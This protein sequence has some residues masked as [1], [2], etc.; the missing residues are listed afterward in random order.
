[1]NADQL[2]R[3]ARRVAAVVAEMNE[4]QRRLAVLRTAPDRY[5]IEPNEPPATYDEFLARTSGLLLHEPPASRRTQ[6]GCPR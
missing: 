6:R 3:A 2:R 1:M 4:A 5:L